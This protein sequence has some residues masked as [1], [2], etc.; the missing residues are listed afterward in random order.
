MFVPAVRQIGTSPVEAD[1]DLTGADLIHRLAELQNPAI[2]EQHKKVQFGAINDFVRNVTGD[3]SAEIEIP[4]HRETVHIRL[5]SH[6]LPL[7]NLGTGVHE[8][9][10]LAA[11]ATVFEHCLICLE[12]PELHLHPLLQRKL[13]RYLSDRTENQYLIT[14]HSGHFLDE[15][16]ST[17]FHVRWDGEQTSATPAIAPA[18]RV[19][20]CADLGY[21]PSDLL[22][23]NAVIWVEG[24]S[25]RLYIRHWLSAADPELIE[26][27]HYSIMFY[28]GRLLSH[29]SASDVEI[30]DFIALRKINQWLSIVIDSDRTAKRARLNATKRRV[31][32]EFDSGP[33]F[34]WVTAGREIENYVAPHVLQDAI[35]ETHPA[36][37]WR[38]PSDL[39][40]GDMCGLLPRTKRQ[41]IDKVKVAHVVTELPIELSVLDLRQRVKALS[42]FVRLANGMED[43]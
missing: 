13:L 12:E 10:M 39:R 34:A 26:G 37:T 24:P 31:V 43:A 18:A 25:D 32:A 22:Q 4:N 28:G 3:A 7:E 21:R 40:Y 42:Q 1:G 41:A 27:V 36:A 19:A 20:L 38:P 11:W 5:G 8:V 2:H 9:I 29:L 33:G 6:V 15:A 23:A 17:V 30:E 14:T 35:A 16:D